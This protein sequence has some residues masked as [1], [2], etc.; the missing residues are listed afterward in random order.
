[1]GLKLNG[2]YISLILAVQIGKW[3][4]SRTRA[5]GRRQ[6]AGQAR[7]IKGSDWPA[8]APGCGEAP[9]PQGWGHQFLGT[10]KSRVGVSNKRRDFPMLSRKY[11]HP[12][13]L[14]GDF[15]PVFNGEHVHFFSFFFF[16]LLVRSG[17]YVLGQCIG[18]C[19]VAR[20]YFEGWKGE[21]SNKMARQLELESLCAE[22]RYSGPSLLHLELCHTPATPPPCPSCSICTGTADRLGVSLR[23]MWNPRVV[24]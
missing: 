6:P 21:C 23:R 4:H 24:F 9:N 12:A 1:M 19:D 22:N 2:R 16:P 5:G 7:G 14:R 8:A 3:P 13:G 15:S 18:P 11:E 20:Y 17:F 10:C